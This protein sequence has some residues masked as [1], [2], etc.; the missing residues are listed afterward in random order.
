VPL[1]RTSE[2]YVAHPVIT[3]QPSKSLSHIE[4]NSS[5]YQMDQI[6]PNINNDIPRSPSPKPILSN[7]LSDSVTEV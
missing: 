4:V 3:I 2:S 6:K 1:T 5:T 7:P